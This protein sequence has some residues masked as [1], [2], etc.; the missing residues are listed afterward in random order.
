LISTGGFSRT[1]LGNLRI[2]IYACVAYG[3]G[4][5]AGSIGAVTLASRMGETGEGTIR[6]V[7]GA[8]LLGLVIFFLRG[9]KKTEWPEVLTKDRLTEALHL[10]LPYFE[11][12]LGKVVCYSLHRAG[13]FF[14]SVLAIGLIGGF[15][16]MGAGWAIVPAQNL[17]LGL[18]LKVAAANSGI[19]LGMGNCIATWPYI[20]NG[21][22][23][24]IFAAPWLVGQVLG[25]LIGTRM[26]INIRSG[27]VRLLLIG[28]LGFSAYGLLTRGFSCI[29]IMPPLPLWVTGLVFISIFSLIIVA[30]IKESNRQEKS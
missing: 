13:W 6:L 1:G 28:F 26:L 7:L 5:F 4:G 30:I 14:L 3:I 18:P 2:C 8:I 25:G 9:G 17:I 20:H 27:F 22:I 21:A 10:H 15:F 23:I 12:S 11:P 29:G 19:L 16:G 24:P